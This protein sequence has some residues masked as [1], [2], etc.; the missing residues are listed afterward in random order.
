MPDLK[1]IR[2]ALGYLI[3]FLI[4]I[5]VFYRIEYPNEVFIAHQDI[6]DGEQLMKQSNAINQP[7]DSENYA[8][9]MDTLSNEL[10]REYQRQLCEIDNAKI[11]S[12]R[13]FDHPTIKQAFKSKKDTDYVNNFLQEFIQSPQVGYCKEI[14]RFGGYYV[15][16]CKYT[17]GQKFVCMDDLLKDLEN[18]ECLIYSFGVKDDWTFEDIMD[19]FG[20]TIYAFDASVDYPARRGK[21]IH[22]EKVFVGTKDEEAKETLALSTILLRNGHEN[23]KISYLKMDIEGN[24]LNGLPMW[25]QEGSLQNVQQIGFEFHLNDDVSKTNDFIKTLKSLYFN[26]N[27]RLISYDPNGCWKNVEP[28]NNGNVNY[29]NLAEIVLMKVNRDKKCF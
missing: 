25:L 4:I 11:N 15:S 9:S 13:A 6:S 27:Y 12:L 5:A 18:N 10:Y 14:K 20:C 24:E 28:K 23:K 2:Y 21:N 1:Q 17:D 8:R 19:S 7:M 22:F 29:Y 16:N 26:G 3:A